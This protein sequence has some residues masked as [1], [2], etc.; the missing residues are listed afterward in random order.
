L[1]CVADIIVLD[2]AAV[3][4]NGGTKAGHMHGSVLKASLL[5]G[6]KRSVEQEEKQRL[7]ESLPEDAACSVRERELLAKLY[8]LVCSALLVRC[9]QAG[10]L[11]CRVQ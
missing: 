6:S 3:V 9:R 4:S 2:G 1:I 8:H 10:G 7:L 11:A 5:E